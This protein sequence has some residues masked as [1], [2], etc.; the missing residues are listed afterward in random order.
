MP[1]RIHRVRPESRLDQL[2]AHLRAHS[3]VE[4]LDLREPLRAAK[5]RIRVFQR[6]DT[7][8]NDPGAFL[9]YRAIMER[10]A[11][12]FPQSE[13]LPWSAFD[14]QTTT[15]PGGDLAMLLNLPDVLTEETLVLIPRAP[16]AARQVSITPAGSVPW[17]HLAMETGRPLPRAIVLHDSFML[18]VLPFLSEGFSR[19]LYVWGSTLDAQLVARERPD[20]VIDERVERSLMAP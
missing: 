13:P 14:I 10:V 18:A 19:V 5:P 8:W 11:T 12:R 15:A 4:L 17:H 6:T 20:I 2:V 16:R 9:A 1:R 3:T 7:H